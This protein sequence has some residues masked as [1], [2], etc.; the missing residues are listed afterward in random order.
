VVNPRREGR[1]SERSTVIELNRELISQSRVIAKGR[2]I[3]DVHRLVLQYGGA[4]AT[5][6]KKSSPVFERDGTYYEYH[7]YEHH[8]IGRFEIKLKTVAKP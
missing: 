6:V 1:K 2:R 7:W 3:R 8:G 5:W 4:A